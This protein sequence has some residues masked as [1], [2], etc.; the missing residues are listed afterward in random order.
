[1]DKIKQKLIDAVT[2]ILGSWPAGPDLSPT[3]LRDDIKTAYEKKQKD[4]PTLNLPDWKDVVKVVEETIYAQASANFDV[5]KGKGYVIGDPE[6]M[7]IDDYFDDTKRSTTDK[8]YYNKSGKDNNVGTER[9]RATDF[10][11]IPQPP[12]PLPP[13]VKIGI[14]HLA[15]TSTTTNGVY[16]EARGDNAQE[17]NQ[18][19]IAIAKAIQDNGLSA[20]FKHFIN[21]ETGEHVFVPIGTAQEQAQAMQRL[22]QSVTG[23]NIEHV[24]R[25]AGR[26]SGYT[27][28]ADFNGDPLDPTNV[29][30]VPDRYQLAALGVAARRAMENKSIG[31]LGADMTAALNTPDQEIVAGKDVTALQARKDLQIEQ[32]PQEIPDINRQRKG[33]VDITTNDKNLKAIDDL[34]KVNDNIV[35]QKMLQALKENLIKTGLDGISDADLAKITKVAQYLAHKD[36]NVGP[37]GKGAPLLKDDGI[38]NAKKKIGDIDLSNIIIEFDYTNDGKIIATDKSPSPPANGKGGVGGRK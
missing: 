26:L 28:S 12:E 36:I 34:I 2:D 19:G 8:A 14:Y 13:S 38:G 5:L 21:E 27:Q 30:G 10:K 3:K 6:Y 18:A 16:I 29:P 24:R 1:M 22:T 32:T 11:F 7:S 35:E 37:D 4:E 31:T 33:F 23:E 15:D 17:L 9:W 20:R 25:V